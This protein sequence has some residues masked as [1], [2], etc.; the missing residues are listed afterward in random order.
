[1]VWG[2]RRSGNIGIA[3]TIDNLIIQTYYRPNGP[4]ETDVP[5]GYIL[6]DP[7]F[8]KDLMMAYSLYRDE[9][10]GVKDDF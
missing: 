4:E 8:M 7:S 2:E 6:V 3:A 1:V 10:E 9:Q 5:S